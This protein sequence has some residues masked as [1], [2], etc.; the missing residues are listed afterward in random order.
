MEPV[1][2]LAQVVANRGLQPEP[3]ATDAL[4]HV[5]QSSP[6]AAG[7]FTSL[8]KAL[9][10]DATL[11]PLSYSTQVV[12]TEDAGR[13]DLV[14]ADVSGPRLICEAKFD[15]TLT[16]AQLGPSYLNRL[17]SGKAGVLLFLVPEDRVAG[18]WPKLL[19][20]P[21]GGF[22]DAAV[23]HSGTVEGVRSVALPGGRTLAVIS[24]RRLLDV[25]AQAI[26]LAGDARA[27]SDLDQLDGLV[28]WRS[29]S[30][31]LPVQPS[32]LPDT[33]GRQLAGI[34]EVVLSAT[35]AASSEKVRN[36]SSDGGPGRWLKTAGGRWFWAG[37]WLKGWGRLGYS[38]V[39][40]TVAAKSDASYVALTEALAPLEKGAA[41]GLIA[42]R[43]KTGPRS[44]GTPLYVPPGA[45]HD[46]AHARIVA[47]LLAFAALIDAAGLG[48]ATAEP[49]DAA[50]QVAHG[51]E[52]STD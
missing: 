15:A 14:G 41:D 10:G 39:W 1:G 26:E 33:A 28:R 31:W 24:W 7:A 38:P 22:E 21:G 43:F 25:L 49:L 5:L 16:T 42:G 32:D 20:G 46:D 34:G 18:L 27:R 2:V 17:V 12:S 35:S 23:V 36:G 44:W 4:T 40:A 37:L 9:T 8:A 6:A 13:P 45:E 47:Q 11:A 50:D 29:R 52:T 3:V 51:S 30:G 48:A 19:H